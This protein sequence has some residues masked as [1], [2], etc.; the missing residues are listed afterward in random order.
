MLSLI[1][2]LAV[3]TV[4]AA[5]AHAQTL[6]ET[7]LYVVSTQQARDTESMMDVVT[8]DDSWLRGELSLR[9]LKSGHLLFLQ[10]VSIRKIDECK[11]EVFETRHSRFNDASYSID[12]A[13]VDLERPIQAKHPI[14]TAG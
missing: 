13:K 1:A 8:Q 4:P 3:T 2:I 6:L 12:F 10:T 9:S 7:V 5:R 14:N 11:F